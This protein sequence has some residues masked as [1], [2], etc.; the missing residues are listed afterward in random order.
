MACPNSSHH[1]TQ[2]D[3]RIACYSPV[4]KPFFKCVT[5]PPL[6]VSATK[7]FISLRLLLSA[8]DNPGWAFWGPAE[9][10]NFKFS[11]WGL[12][13]FAKPGWVC[14]A[15]TNHPRA[16]VTVG[17]GCSPLLIRYNFKP[18]WLPLW[19]ISA[20]THPDVHSLSYFPRSALHLMGIVTLSA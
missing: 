3:R 18:Q 20:A 9:F 8:N 15:M 16:G 10:R 7:R 5:A 14:S 12:R 2:I 4:G 1:G 6:S 13:P 19:D 11:S 17:Q